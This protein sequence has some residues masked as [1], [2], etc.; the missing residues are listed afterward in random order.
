MK[1]LN[2][3]SIVSC[4]DASYTHLNWCE[5][6]TRERVNKK[7]YGND[8]E[9]LSVDRNGKKLFAVIPGILKALLIT[10]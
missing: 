2:T 10:L 6:T 5:V 3:P 1:L 8:N 7:L 4:T 9:K